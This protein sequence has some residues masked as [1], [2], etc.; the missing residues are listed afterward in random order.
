MRFTL[1]TRGHSIGAALCRNLEP[2]TYN[3]QLKT[4][5]L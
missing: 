3:L 1:P 5:N 2:K 4:Y